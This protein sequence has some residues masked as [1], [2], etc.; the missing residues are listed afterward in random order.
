M[1]MIAIGL[2]LVLLRKTRPKRTKD[3]VELRIS[4]SVINFQISNFREFF[5]ARDRAQPIESSSINHCNY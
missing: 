5:H 1:I 4:R 2:K 3:R